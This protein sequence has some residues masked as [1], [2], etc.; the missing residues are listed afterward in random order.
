MIRTID[1][2][3]AVNEY[4]YFAQNDPTGVKN[5]KGIHCDSNKKGGYLAKII[6]DPLRKG[7]K[8]NGI[9]ANLI[10][11]LG[12]NSFGN[13]TTIWDS[14]G[15]PKKFIFNQHNRLV[16]TISSKPFQYEATFRYDRNMNPIEVKRSFDHNV[17]APDGAVI[18][19]TS[20]IQQKYEYNALNNVVRITTLSDGQTILQ[21]IER[22][23]SENIICKV[24]PMGNKT[25]YI[26]D[27]RNQV[28]EKRF[29]VGSKEETSIQYTYTKNGRRSSKTNGTG[30][31]ISYQYDG[32]HRYLGYS[33][34]GGTSRK[35]WYN[36]VNRITRIDVTGDPGFV[37][38]EGKPIKSNSLQLLQSWF[39]YDELNRRVRTDRSWRDTRTGK[40]LGKSNWDR[41]NGIVSA[42]AEYDDNHRPS[43]IWYET[44]NIVTLQYDGAN[45]VISSSDANGESISMRYDEN[46]NVVRIER[47]GPEEHDN[48][49]R[50][51]NIV[52]LGYDELDRVVWRSV[53]GE[54][55]ES[56][57][58]NALGLRT[59]H[60]KRAG[61]QTDFLHDGFGRFIGQTMMATI[62]NGG[63]TQ[64]L[65]RHVNY[66]NNSLIT[67]RINAIGSRTD[68]QYDSLNRLS[69]IIYPNK[70]KKT[71][72]RDGNGKIARIVDPNGN[73]ISHSFDNHSRL[74]ERRVQSYSGEE[75][76]ERYHYDGLNRLVSATSNG[77][78]ILRQHDSL[79]RILL[80]NQNG[81]ILEYAYDAPGNRTKITYPSGE[82][83]RKTYDIRGRITEVWDGQNKLISSYVYRSG[84]NLQKQV[85]ADV[86]E[87]DYAYNPCKNSLRELI[88]RTKD[89]DILEG[90]RYRYT[91]A[92]KP[93]SEVQLYRGERYGECYYFDSADRLV[94]VKYD[95]EDVDDPAS[96]FGREVEFDLN[97]S[98]LLKRIITRDGNGKILSSQGGVESDINNYLSLGDR[99]YEYDRNGNRIREDRESQD[100]FTEKKCT[101]NYSNRITNIELLDSEGHV[102][103]TVEYKYDVFGRQIRLRITDDQGSNEFTRI[104][105][106]RQLIEERQNGKLVKSYLYG[107]HTDEPLVMRRYSSKGKDYYYAYNGRG[108]VTALL[109]DAGNVLERYRYEFSRQHSVSE[110]NGKRVP[111]EVAQR[112]SSYANS[113]FIAGTISDDV[114][115]NLY[116]PNGSSFDRFSGKLDH[117][118]DGSIGGHGNCTP[119]PFGDDFTMVDSR[120]D[121][122]MRSDDNSWATPYYESG[123]R[124]MENA[125]KNN[126]EGNQPDGAWATAYGLVNY[127]VGGLIE[128]GEKIGDAVGKAAVEP[129]TQSPEGAGYS[130]PPDAGTPSGGCCTDD[131]TL[132][133]NNKTEVSEDEGEGNGG[134]GG[135]G[136]EDG[137]EGGNDGEQDGDDGCECES[138]YPDPDGGGEDPNNGQS[139]EDRAKGYSDCGPGLPGNMSGLL[140][141]TVG[142]CNGEIS[143]LGSIGRHQ[144]DNPRSCG[145]GHSNSYLFGIGGMNPALILNNNRINTW[146]PSPDPEWGIMGPG[147]GGDFTDPSLGYT[148]PPPDG[149]ISG[150][151]LGG[152]PDGGLT[153]PSTDNGDGSPLPEQSGGTCGSGIPSGTPNPDCSRY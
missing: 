19:Q 78:T 5:R 151:I 53:N 99:K 66:N 104:W 22:D 149:V 108:Y 40:S 124:S 94:K 55:P 86:M 95:V 81:S 132:R 31:T 4:W 27:A 73:I 11:E 47:L 12:Y 76:V 85:I 48:A 125:L 54:L 84:R 88:Y 17:L 153:P 52:A 14:K 121:P 9:A 131:T 145:N 69:T 98:G 118:S 37:T 144:D 6:R 103:K 34:P 35:Q 51:Q 46:G 45:R 62:K 41:T 28:V 112:K 56:Y 126:E 89:G 142:G 33:N 93:E 13:V 97:P 79:S 50:F 96:K 15:N 2:R 42:I 3:N 49:E 71:F 119:N 117:L 105:N 70:Q 61:V 82:V 7:R 111:T 106:G 90:T 138:G 110:S 147:A 43:K 30:K 74:T 148:D 141:H 123:A 60:K 26:F 18:S 91:D 127:A 135:Y 57:T 23:A 64:R 87:V 36:E 75:H 122:G 101:F 120:H 100:E 134:V 65:T 21:S 115:E 129:D 130:E 39:H 109:D 92:C 20:M 140:A 10:T 80:E 58:Y 16:K 38:K 29:G 24:Q 44:G 113:I 116:G 114:T 83:V 63:N 152:A 32:F 25:E 137:G 150:G 143:G 77:V 67:A 72:E 107:A 68:Y 59:T 8:Q 133:N 136:G 139:I 146:D 102:I 1:T 128:L